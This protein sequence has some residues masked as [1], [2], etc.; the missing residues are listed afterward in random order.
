MDAYGW[1]EKHS[2]ITNL[3]YFLLLFN[4]K[5]FIIVYEYEKLMVISMMEILLFGCCVFGHVDFVY[6][7][8]L[9]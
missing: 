4:N 5:Y 2:Y 8:G 9:S 6:G 1:V 7:Y 3:L